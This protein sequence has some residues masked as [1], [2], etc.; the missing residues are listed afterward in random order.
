MDKINQKSIN[1][2]KLKI[3]TIQIIRR[4]SQIL[5]LFFFAGIFSLAFTGIGKVYSLII[6]NGFSFSKI[7]I[8]IVPLSIV[9]ILTVLFGRFFCGWLCA[10]GA[11]NDFLFM[12]SK[13][14]FKNKFKINKTLDSQLK[15]LKYVVLVLII[16]F[17]WTLNIIPGNK[18]SPW[19]AFAQ[20]G[21]FFSVVP[22]MPIAFIIL[23]LIAVGAMFIERFFCR[24]L[25]P[26]GAILAI[27]SKLKLAKINKSRTNC[28]KCRLCSTSCPMD[29]DLNSMDKVK[30]G[31]CISCLKCVNVCPKKNAKVSLFTKAFNKTVYI[32][33]AIIVFLVIN[34]S[35]SFILSNTSTN[36]SSTTGTTNNTNSNSNSKNGTTTKTSN[37]KYKDG[38]YEGTADGFHPGLT[39]SV[40]VKSD[41]ITKIK[42]VSTDDTPGFCEQPIQTIPNEIISA[43]STNVDAVSGAT[44]TSKGIMN[45]VAAALDKA[46]L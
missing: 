35:E 13:K 17:V 18:Y 7:S 1:T 20:A 21:D 34:F 24:Y 31:E 39:V 26:L 27:L 16:I 38:V 40:T 25:C 42:I 10:F 23:F 37:S 9:I 41:K 4:M 36:T 5:S 19:I 28:N 6:S 8:F 43:Q 15:Y 14:V 33:S 11:L 29:I 45:A 22:T 46:K 32:V 44:F 2:K 30:S 12:F 3:S